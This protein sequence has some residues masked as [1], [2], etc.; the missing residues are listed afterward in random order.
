MAAALKNVWWACR[1]SGSSAVM[2]EN[3]RNPA[4]A[5]LGRTPAQGKDD[6]GRSADEEGRKIQCHALQRRA[7]VGA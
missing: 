2:R 6:A 3:G 7:R 1:M 4:G 5:G